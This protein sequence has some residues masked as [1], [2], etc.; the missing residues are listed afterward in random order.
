MSVWDMRRLENKIR[1]EKNIK[2]PIGEFS[3]IGTHAKPACLVPSP[4]NRIPFPVREGTD[5]NV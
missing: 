4:K 3:D 2:V 1:D 5:V